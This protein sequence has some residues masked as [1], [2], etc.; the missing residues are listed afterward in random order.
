MS[1]AENPVASGFAAAATWADRPMIGANA[2]MAANVR[3]NLW[4]WAFKGSMLERLRGLIDGAPSANGLRHLPNYKMTI[5]GSNP[6][7]D[8]ARFTFSS[9]VHIRANPPTEKKC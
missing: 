2:I 5:E 8:S 4:E 7:T 1:A 6:A 3:A 9:L